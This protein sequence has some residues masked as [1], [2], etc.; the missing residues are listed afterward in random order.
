VQRALGILGAGSTA[1][2]A[3][4]PGRQL[5]ARKSHQ[6]IPR[7]LKDRDPTVPVIVVVFILVAALILSIS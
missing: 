5:A 3:P 7:L 6:A 4:L 1:A 2:P